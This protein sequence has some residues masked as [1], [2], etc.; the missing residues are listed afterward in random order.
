M[1]TAKKKTTTKKTPAKKATA[2]VEPTPPVS[3]AP[4]DTPE[5]PAEE[6]PAEA[7]VDA[8]ELSVDPT[9]AEDAAPE[10]VVPVQAAAPAAPT[11]PPLP[12][13]PEGHTWQ[14]DSATGQI[15][16]VPTEAAAAATQAASEEAERTAVTGKT[17]RNLRGVP[18]HLRLQGHGDKSYRVELMPRNMAGDTKD[19][20]AACT[21]DTTFIRS[22]DMGLFEI[23]SKQEARFNAQQ[24]PLNGYR[25]RELNIIHP[26]EQTVAH[27]E[28]EQT[29]KGKSAQ[30]TKRDLQ[31]AQ[32]QQNPAQGANVYES[33]GP[34]V[35]SRPGSD[36][37]LTAQFQSV[38]TR[39]PASPDVSAMQ[40]DTGRAEHAPD[41]LVNK[42]IMGELPQVAGIQR[43]QGM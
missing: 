43:V 1:A 7:P 35:V 8:P 13:P 2:P 32:V 37:Q 39:R 27:Y 29:G 5:V 16:L 30:L 41:K 21:Q 22:Y 3:E 18:V 4:D 25:S 20:P 6:S 26:D 28:I 40:Q 34:Q 31:P 11:P 23:I 17:I 14:L 10:L 38:Q 15:T 42:G 19:I 33:V 24:V 9:P 36:P 12:A